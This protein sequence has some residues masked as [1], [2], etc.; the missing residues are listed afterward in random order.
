[1]F[2]CPCQESL[3]EEM[4]MSPGSLLLVFLLSLDVIPPTL[5]QDNYRYIKF[6]T[7]HY[8][9][10]PKGRDDRYCESMMKE[11]KL[12]SPCKDVNTFIHGTKKKWK[13]SKPVH[14]KKGNFQLSRPQSSP[15]SLCPYLYT[16]SM[17]L[18]WSQ[19]YI[20]GSPVLWATTGRV[21]SW[22]H[23]HGSKP[24]LVCWMLRPV[25]QSLV[26]QPTSRQPTGHQL[27]LHLTMDA[28]SSLAEMVQAGSQSAA[29]PS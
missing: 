14:M 7:Q 8:D 24:W 15:S 21:L 19:S 13:L 4:V 26:T 2:F 3:L 1:M 22:S 17:R 20:C 12:T 9:A 6:L 27:V 16:H 10:K 11:R 29:S 18:R 5:A 25:V 28:W 23:C